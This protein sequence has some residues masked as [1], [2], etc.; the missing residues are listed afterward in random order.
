M[1]RDSLGIFSRTFWF[2]LFTNKD[3]ESEG[4]RRTNEGREEKRNGRMRNKEVE[5][6]RGLID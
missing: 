2:Y 6:R 5:E 4:K 3:F 1:S